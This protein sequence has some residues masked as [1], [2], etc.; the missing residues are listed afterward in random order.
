MVFEFFELENWKIW[1]LE[2]RVIYKELFE[3]K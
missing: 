2:K 1:S 3:I